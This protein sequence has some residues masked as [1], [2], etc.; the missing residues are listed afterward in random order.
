[1]TRTEDNGTVTLV[2]DRWEGKKLNSPNDIV[3]R[4]DGQVYFT[5]PA[6]TAIKEPQE[7]GFNGVYHV[8]PAGEMSVIT[9]SLKRPNGVALSPD[10]SILYVADSTE[11]TLVAFDLDGRGNASR[12]RVLIRGIDGSPDGLK[13]AESGNLYIACRGV[14]VYTPQGK[15]LRM[16]E[17]PE[18]PANCAFGD[19]DLHTLYVTAR[20]SL[21]RI[22][23]PE[24][25]SLQF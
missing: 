25:G 15:L 10:G 11:R 8:T 19:Q 22:R 16:I 4:R 24:K 12:E 14:A 5:D 23:V 7:V 18:Q 21:Y 9:K 17:F 3:V 2:A 6:S 1:V 13:I 20:T